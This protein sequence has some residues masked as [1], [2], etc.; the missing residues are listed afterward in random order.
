M[1]SMDISSSI[2]V[3]S[4]QKQTSGNEISSV[5]S[6]QDSFPVDVKH[7]DVNVSLISLSGIKS[8]DFGGHKAKKTATLLSS[9]EEVR[10][11]VSFIFNE[12]EV[13]VSVKSNIGNEPKSF[14]MNHVSSAPLVTITKFPSIKSQRSKVAQW[15]SNGQSS[16][17]HFRAALRPEKSAAN[18]M[19]KAERVVVVVGLVKGKES[20]PL[21]VTNFLISGED[22]DMLLS[23]PVQ[24]ISDP[25]LSN[26]QETTKGIFKR[27]KSMVLGTSFA[28]DSSKY[29][30]DLKGEATL[31]VR[32]QVQFTGTERN[33]VN[34]EKE[35]RGDEPSNRGRGL[36]ERCGIEEI[37][38]QLLHID[39]PSPR[40]DATFVGPR[41]QREEDVYSESLAGTLA[42][43]IEGSVL[44]AVAEETSQAS[45]F[46]IRPKHE[47][48]MKVDINSNFMNSVARA[49]DRITHACSQQCFGATERKAKE[50]NPS[51][52]FPNSTAVTSPMKVGV[53]DETLATSPN[54]IIGQ[55]VGKT[56]RGNVDMK[57]MMMM[58]Q[59]SSLAEASYDGSADDTAD[60][61]TRATNDQTS[62]DDVSIGDET[63]DSVEAAKETLQRY[64]NRLGK[65]IVDI[66]IDDELSVDDE[67][68]LSSKE[69]AR[70]AKKKSVPRTRGTKGKRSSRR[71]DDS[72]HGESSSSSSSSSSNSSMQDDEASFTAP[73]VFM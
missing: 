32:L 26:M 60:E 56:P 47:S 71:N 27:S 3:R 34:P 25:N 36:D 31:S 18:S 29:R 30:L 20:M 50:N 4:N 38:T 42:G 2:I 46:L 22:T 40:K 13:A 48:E 41:S 65:D 12:K 8:D 59:V 19:L 10:A 43:E 66:V 70:R 67:S 58:R 45:S 23:L 39:D 33:D 1:A 69:P 52:P 73:I 54:N 57:K 37:E 9:S 64:A 63:M 15:G 49:V 11:Y 7:Y 44:E 28:G 68:I 72:Y 35:K 6:S 16:T 21:G 62:E 14:T 53:D 55:V 61:S 24:N 5:V 51:S 17:A